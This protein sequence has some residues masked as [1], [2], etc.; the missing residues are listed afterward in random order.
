[1]YHFYNLIFVIYD[2]LNK[3]K[4]ILSTNYS[5]IQIIS[6]L[7]Y[8]FNLTYYFRIDRKS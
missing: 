5:S 2:D 1:M 4:K 8:D 3:K 6:V 7:I